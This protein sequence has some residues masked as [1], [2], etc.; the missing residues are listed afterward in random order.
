MR[1]ETAGCFHLRILGVSKMNTLDD[2][3]LWVV[4]LSYVVSVIGAFVSLNV[5]NYVRAAGGR[6]EIWW[7]ILAAVIFGGCAIWAMH[8]IGMLAYRPGVAITYDINLTLTSLVIPILF[9]FGGFYTVCRWHNLTALLIAGTIVGL[10]VT[11]MHYTGMAAMRIDAAM[12]HVQWIVAISALIAVVAAIVALHIFA[13]WRGSVRQL[14]PFLMGVAVCGMHYT[15]MS[16][17]RLKPTN[18][19][20]PIDYYQGA[21]DG[22]IM[23]IVTSG[24]VVF[25]LA[26]GVT[27]V[28]SRQLSDLK[29][30]SAQ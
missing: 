1:H 4:G 11:T 9:T 16:A 29:T 25:A 30:Y 19:M 21:W 5:F 27:M 20:E 22:S 8:F 7:T 13:H 10:G 3:N 2:Y 28:T 17:M 6:V 14:S 24:A 23:A 12:T 15:G 26:V 18:R